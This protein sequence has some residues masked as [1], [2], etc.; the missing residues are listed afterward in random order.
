MRMRYLQK[1]RGD[2]LK[3]SIK[4]MVVPVALFIIFY[5]VDLIYPDGWFN[6][7]SPAA[8]RY[9][10]LKELVLTNFSYGVELLRS[11]NELAEENTRLRRLIED[12]TNSQFQYKVLKSEYERLQ[13]SMEVEKSQR[14]QALVLVRP[15]QSLYDT[16]IV[17]AGNADGVKEKNLIY[18]SDSFLLGEIIKVGSGTSIGRL[19]SSSG[20]EIAVRL[21]NGLEFTASGRGGGTFELKIPMEVEAQIGE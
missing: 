13:N 18:T 15:P 21:K 10:S 20:S 5:G 16:V 17:D 11:K 19:F 4:I 1:N 14:R 9:W 3:R 6:L 12:V 7:F 2:G 8:R